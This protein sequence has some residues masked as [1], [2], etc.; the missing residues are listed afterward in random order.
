MLVQV[1]YLATI[2]SFNEKYINYKDNNIIN[3]SHENAF[4]K[5]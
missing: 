3:K 2:K 4:L 1:Y 5:M